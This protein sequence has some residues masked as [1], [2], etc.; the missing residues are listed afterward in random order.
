VSHPGPRGTS[1]HEEKARRGGW[2]ASRIF[3]L[4]LRLVRRRGRLGFW[5]YTL[6]V[7]PLR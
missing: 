4:R 2:Q 3:S 6:Q 1:D 5:E 7:K